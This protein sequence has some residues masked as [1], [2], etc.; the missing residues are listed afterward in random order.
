M[1]TGF[2]RILAYESW[3]CDGMGGPL[4]SPERSWIMF[5]IVVQQPIRKQ[6]IAVVSVI[7]EIL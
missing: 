5:T 2:R 3:G 6:S 1:S 7:A 4:L